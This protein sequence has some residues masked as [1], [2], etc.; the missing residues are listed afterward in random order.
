M[1][2]PSSSR[3]ATLQ[4][5]A[6]CMATEFES[7]AKCAFEALL[8]FTASRQQFSARMIWPPLDSLCTSVSQVRLE[9]ASASSF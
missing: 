4:G 3:A 8:S 5:A 9:C 7:T 6:P 2:V 1:P